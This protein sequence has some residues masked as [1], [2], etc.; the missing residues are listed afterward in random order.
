MPDSYID[1]LS[2]GKFG[3]PES[4][5][6]AILRAKADNRRRWKLWAI[7]CNALVPNVGDIHPPD[8]KVRDDN[9]GGNFLLRLT[10]DKVYYVEVEDRGWQPQE[11][12][13]S[14]ENGVVTREARGVNE[15]NTRLID[16][17]SGATHQATQYY[18]PDNEIAGPAYALSRAIVEGE[19]FHEPG[20]YLS[21]LTQELIKISSYA[22]EAQ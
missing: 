19:S 4:E 3:P 11:P 18:Y 16:V 17:E 12:G 14:D 13:E 8:F 10:T 1:G 22:I 20:H 7:T 21:Y 15:I 2:S 6:Q 9:Y 5:Q